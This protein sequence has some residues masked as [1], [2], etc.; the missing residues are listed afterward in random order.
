MAA[1]RVISGSMDLDALPDYPIDPNAWLGFHG[2][3]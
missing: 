2:V 1:L 3:I